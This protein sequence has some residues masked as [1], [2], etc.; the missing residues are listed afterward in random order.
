M[1]DYFELIHEGI[2]ITDI[3]IIDVHAHLGP[4]YNFHVP[5][6]SPG[7]M[8]WMMDRCGIDKTIVSPTPGITSD[9]VL[10]NNMMLDAIK[11]HRGRLYGACYVSGHYPEL[12]MEELD[13]CFEA[14]RD[15]AVMK[16]HPFEAKC[17]MDDRRMKKIYE[18]ANDR[19]LFTIVHTWLD[20]D[21]Y[22]NQDMF[23]GVA[24][25]Y[26]GIK[27]LMGH[28]GGPYGGRH[29]VEIAQEIPNVY[30]DITMS[31][32]PARQTEFFVKEVGS[33]RVFF[34]TDNPFIDPRPHIGRIGLADISHEDKV[35]IFGANARRLIKI[36]QP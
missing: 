19:E 21:Q 8:V 13:R 18:Y 33:E 7:E 27:W 3:E 26:P 5:L 32:C 6:N 35:N 10:G 24:K 2:P 9:M 11:S 22:G 15:V 30:L 31:M 34:A 23:A 28:S 12:S 20:E 1:T 17:K 36:D 4:S 29:A 16:I 25:D 14:D